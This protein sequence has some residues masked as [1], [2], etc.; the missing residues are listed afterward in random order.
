M[1]GAA[2]LVGELHAGRGR[3]DDEHAA[4]GQLPRV[5]IVERAEASDGFGYGRAQG[6]HVRRVAGAARDDDAAAEDLAAVRRMR[7]P[8]AAV[9][10]AVTSVCV[11]TGAA[12]ASA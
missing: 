8:P 11:R 2:N 4:V 10:R 6:R 1:A 12:V 9:V 7:Y 3:A 5:A